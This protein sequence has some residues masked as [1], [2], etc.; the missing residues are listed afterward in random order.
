MLDYFPAV[1]GSP[2][3]VPQSGD[4]PRFAPYPLSLASEKNYVCNLQFHAGIGNLASEMI[5]PMMI[6]TLPTC[7]S[8]IG[9]LATLPITQTGERLQLAFAA[10]PGLYQFSIVVDAG[11][12]DWE[13]L[14]VNLE[15]FNNQGQRTGPW[16][17]DIT[18]NNVP[19]VPA[20]W[21][22]L[23]GRKLGLWYCQRVSLEDMAEKRFRGNMAFYLAE[24]GEHEPALRAV[25][26]PADHLALCH[27]H[28]RSGGLP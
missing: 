4:Q 1:R 6:H 25:P 14:Y 12:F 24:A 5:L 9:E 16:D 28:S 2:A 22:Y 26:F 17:F 3:V 23:D 15:L 10:P 8:T 27:A 13:E 19:L 18:N 11:A 21:V 7:S 20:Y